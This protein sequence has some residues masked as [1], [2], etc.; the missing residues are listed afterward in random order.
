MGICGLARRAIEKGFL[1]LAVELSLE[2]SLEK[3]TLEAEEY[4]ALVALENAIEEG[5]VHTVGRRACVNAMEQ[6]VWAEI[7]RLIEGGDLDPRG[8]T[9][10]GEI[11]AHALSRLPA[12]YA[13]TDEGLALAL[14]EAG[15]SLG[16]ETRRAVAQAATACLPSHAYH[17]ERRALRPP[18]TGLNI[19][20]LME[21]WQGSVGGL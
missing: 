11:A 18:A 1:E 9:D 3:P 16:E 17:P 13:T 2:Q 20:G 7:A 5:R 21:R 8:E 12:R 19:R 15:Q 6:L 10:L 14:A 4:E